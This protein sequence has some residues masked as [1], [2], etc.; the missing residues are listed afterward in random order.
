M[1][2]I[3]KIFFGRRGRERVEK[4]VKNIW[5]E[6]GGWRGVEEVVKRILHDRTMSCGRRCAHILIIF[7]SLPAP[8][9]Y[10]DFDRFALLHK[11]PICLLFFYPYF[12]MTFWWIRHSICQFVCIPSGT[13]VE[14]DYHGRPAKENGWEIVSWLSSG[15]RKIE[16]APFSASRRGRVIL[17][18]YEVSTISKYNCHCI[19]YNLIV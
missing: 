8:M 6:G 19:F 18:S 9:L 15:A 14:P 12:S 2:G 11:S 7:F 3:V 5:G 10:C 16:R 13:I 17:C 4:I 1:G